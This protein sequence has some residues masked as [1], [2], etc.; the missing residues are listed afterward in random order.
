M[1]PPDRK[2]FATEAEYQKELNRLTAEALR[3][4]ME[5]IYFPPNGTFK[6]YEAVCVL[7]EDP[8][9]RIHRAAQEKL[10]SYGPAVCPVIRAEL[11][12]H[13]KL[14]DPSALALVAEV[15]HE[16]QRRALQELIDMVLRSSQTGQDLPLEEMFLALSRFGYPETDEQKVRT[17]LDDIAL[18]VHALFMKSQQHNELGLLLSMNQAFFEEFHFGGTDDEDYHNPTNTYAHVLILRRTGIPISLSVLY[19]LVAERADLNVCGVGMPAHF[20]VYHPEL[21]VFID[22]FNKGSFLSQE[23]CK[24]F[25][26]GAGFSFE[27]SMLEKASNTAILLRMIRNLIFAY[28]KRNQEWEVEALHELSAAILEAMNQEEE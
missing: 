14:T 22:S 2:N 26:Q 20:V 25:I 12:T 9:P 18:R 1:A 5:R 6:E 23:D 3:T 11:E 27:P 28:T 21:N 17:L 13:E 24:R 7:L 19:L 10:R 4:G 8:D 15:L 16:F